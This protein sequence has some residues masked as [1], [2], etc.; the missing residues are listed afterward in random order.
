MSTKSRFFDTLAFVKSV[1]SLQYEA[2]NN[3]LRFEIKP[4]DAKKLSKKMPKGINLKN[5]TVEFESV[6]IRNQ[7]AAEHYFDTNFQILGLTANE[8]W[9]KLAIKIW[10][11]DVDSSKDSVSGRFL[12]ILHNYFSVLKMAVDNITKS[13]VF[14]VILSVI[15]GIPFFKNISIDEL[16]AFAEA[17]NP[18][19]KD[20]MFCGIFFQRL[21][22]QLETRLDVAQKIVDRQRNDIAVNTASLYMSAVSALL[23]KKP[24]EWACNLSKD[25]KSTNEILKSAAIQA[26]GNLLDHSLINKKNNSSLCKII[27][28]NLDEINELFKQSA[29]KAISESESRTNRFESKLHTMIKN[30]DFLAAYFQSQIL[31]KRKEAK[32]LDS[33]ELDILPQICKVLCPTNID[34]TYLDYVLTSLIDESKNHE[35]IISCLREWTSVATDFKINQLISRLDSTCWT[36]VKSNELISKLSISCLLSEDNKFATSFELLLNHAMPSQKDLKL[37]L[38]FPREKLAKL[39]TLE[40]ELLVLKT[41]AFV[42]FSEYQVSLMLSLL[43]TPRFNNNH[44][45]MLLEVLVKYVGYDF[46]GLLLTGLSEVEKSSKSKLVSKLCSELK[47]EINAKYELRK[48]LPYRKELQIPASMSDA[49]KKAYNSKMNVIQKQAESKSVFLQLVT[50]IPIKAGNRAYNFDQ[51]PLERSNEM[52]KIEVSFVVPKSLITDPLGLTHR[53]WLYKRLRKPN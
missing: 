6:E 45:N 39:D 53:I 21:S 31:F 41:L 22:G 23:K 50:K 36:I 44:Y 49:F 26:I 9:M 46:P 10:R 47:K 7:F 34:C 11:F 18:L 14:E 51:L 28:V 1:A 27:E 16:Y 15:S 35:L 37:V 33:K 17:Q 3:N 25:A 29:L 2:K 13:D 30:N 48:K 52:Q 40:F 32:R 8:N 38:S 19:T 5:G 20:D 24:N 4:A 42:T 12:G 43:K